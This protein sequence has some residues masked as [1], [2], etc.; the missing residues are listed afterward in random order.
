MKTTNVRADDLNYD[1]YITEKYDADIRRVIPGHEELHK[2][3]EAVVLEYVKNHVVNRIADLGT[4]TALTAE[5]ILKLVPKAK[6]IA[7]DFSEQMLGGA[8]KRLE[9]YDVEFSIGDYSEINFG[10][11]FDIVV[12]VIGLHHQN[13]EGK[14]KVMQKVYDSLVP[15]GLFILGDLVTYRDKAEAAYAD[16]RHYYHLVKNAEDETSLKEWAYHHKFLNDLA[17]LEDQVDWLNVSGFSKVEVR[18]KHLNT[19]LI[20]AQK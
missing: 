13:A 11:E 4:G 7:N 19:A 10:R 17:P 12:C 20:I 16:A 5:R 9:G 1:H 8:R 6:L 18:Y 15:G 14:K 2:E 3:I